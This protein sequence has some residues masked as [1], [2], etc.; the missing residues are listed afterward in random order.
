MA[1]NIVP[2][3]GENYP[4][5]E[6]TVDRL[7]PRPHPCLHRQLLGR[8]DVVDGALDLVGVPTVAVIGLDSFVPLEEV[9][10]DG[11][12]NLDVRLLASGVRTLNPDKANPPDVDTQLVLQGRL[13]GILVGAEG[14]PLLRLPLLGDSKV[15]SI[16]QHQEVIANVVDEPSIKINL[17]FCEGGGQETR[18]KFGEKMRAA[19]RTNDDDGQR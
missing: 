11:I 5:L 10:E 7:V 12:K 3:N 15:G 1:T 14:V 18:A 9:G 13:A 17:Q 6:A 19:G 4:T 8:G 16:D 2:K